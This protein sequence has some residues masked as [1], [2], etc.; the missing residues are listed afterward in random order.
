MNFLSDAAFDRRI[1]AVCR[2]DG[3]GQQ[4]G[5]RK[6]LDMETAEHASEA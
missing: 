4:H 6:A 2:M 3:A 5:E 1:L